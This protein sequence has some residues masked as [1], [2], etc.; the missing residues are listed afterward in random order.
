MSEKKK[1]NIQLPEY[2]YE[3]FQE[4]QQENELS[5]SEAA[6]IVI[7]AFFEPKLETKPTEEVDSCS[8]D[9]IRG[10]LKKLQERVAQLEQ[11]NLYL[12]ARAKV[13]YMKK[14][15]GLSR[16]IETPLIVHRPTVTSE[17]DFFF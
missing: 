16:C 17:D 2:L 14:E 3:C 4:F 1:L 12:K 7:G 13:V 8:Y 10:T 15:R 6:E 9:A 11:D 5:T